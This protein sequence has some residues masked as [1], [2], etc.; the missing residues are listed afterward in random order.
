MPNPSTSPH[1][2]AMKTIACAIGL[3]ACFLW[4]MPM[5]YVTY[6]N[7]DMYQSGMHIGGWAWL[8]ILCVFAYTCLAWTPLHAARMVVSGAA[9]IF[10]LLLMLGLGESL[11]WGVVGL[12]LSTFVCLVLAFFDM[13]N[14]RVS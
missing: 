7:I 11:A 6:M 4:F 9:L 8:I 3:V 10:S 12:S 5:R 14:A 1:S 2:T 13:Y